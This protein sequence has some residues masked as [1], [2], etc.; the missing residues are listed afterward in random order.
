M[1]DHNLNIKVDVPDKLID[2]A[3][4]PVNNLANPVAIS[5]GDGLKSMIDLVFSQFKYWSQKREIIN[6]HK[7]KLLKEKLD[8]DTKEISPE[9][10]CEP[11]SQIISLVYDNLKYCIDEDSLRDMFAKLIVSSVNKDTVNNVHPAFP[12]MIA[13]MSPLEAELLIYFKNNPI[14]PIVE[15]R[16]I[17]K[18]KGYDVFKSNVMLYKNPQ[19][20][21]DIDLAA[22][23]LTNLERLGLITISYM[24]SL[25]DESRYLNYENYLNNLKVTMPNNY[26]MKT[27]VVKTT[28]LGKVFIKV[29]V[30]P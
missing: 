1:S 2:M 13:Q 8:N 28:P 21:E 17:A 19:T 27:G 15:Y 29:C 20:L 22:F 23:A 9:K 10:L 16:I 3:S 11:S 5:T 7:L 18:T 30:S 24:E 25:T 12:S 6:N 26:K 4:E 14:S